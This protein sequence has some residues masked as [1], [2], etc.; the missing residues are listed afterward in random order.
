MTKLALY[1]ASNGTT[2]SAIAA[3]VKVSRGYMSL[4]VS[5]EKKPGLRVALAIEDATGGVV[6]ARSW[7]GPDLRERCRQLLRARGGL[8]LR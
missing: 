6:L 7:P 4:L 8:S 5:G 2:Q 3:A 1:I